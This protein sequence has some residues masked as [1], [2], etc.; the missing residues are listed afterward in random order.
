MRLLCFLVAILAIHLSC[1]G[2]CKIQGVVVD[3][4]GKG[5]SDTWIQNLSSKKPFE[6]TDKKGRFWIRAQVGDTLEIENIY[7]RKKKYVVS[8]QNEIK[9]TLDLIPG[10]ILVVTKNYKPSKLGAFYGFN[11]NT[12]GVFGNTGFLNVLANTDLQV[13]YATN[14]SKNDRADA[15]LQKIFTLRNEWDLSA[16]VSFHKADFDSNQFFNYQL[17]LKPYTNYRIFKWIPSLV[18]AHINYNS[19]EDIESFGYGIKHSIYIPSGVYFNGSFLKYRDLN[20]WTLGTKYNNRIVDIG[21][22]YEE[23]ETYNEF[24]IYLSKTVRF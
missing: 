2:Q 14:F 13:G 23:L 10:C 20:H 11:Y 9:V 1:D 7:Y 5:I 4:A 8:N 17:I 3:S 22:Q 12:I 16:T 6:V 18:I 21:I 24:S 19:N 15:S